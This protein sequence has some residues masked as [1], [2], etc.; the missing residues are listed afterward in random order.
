M[1]GKTF[2]CFYTFTVT[3]LQGSGVINFRLRPVADLDPYGFLLGLL[4][5]HLD[6]SARIALE[7]IEIWS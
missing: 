2:Y 4:N 3:S 1:L 6:P 7:Y 5:P